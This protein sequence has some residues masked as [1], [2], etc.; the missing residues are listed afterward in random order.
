MLIR[1]T[2]CKH[3]IKLFCFRELIRMMA[4]SP[5]EN[6]AQ[7]TRIISPPSK[8]VNTVCPKKSCIENGQNLLPAYWFFCIVY[9]AHASF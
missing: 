6:A 1:D 3:Y 2:V 7:F 9:I 8:Q 4:V 5:R